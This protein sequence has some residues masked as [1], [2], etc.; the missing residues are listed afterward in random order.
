MKPVGRLP[1]RLSEGLEKRVELIRLDAKILT[2]LQ[3][4]GL[5]SFVGACV[6]ACG[7]RL[8]N[9]CITGALSDQF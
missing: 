9:N 3:H 1:I 6:D 4:S 8:N 2:L 5:P 7:G